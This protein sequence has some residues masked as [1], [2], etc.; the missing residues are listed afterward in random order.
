MDFKINSIC[1]KNSSKYFN[2]DNLFYPN[3][4][5]LYTQLMKNC[6]DREL[7][8]NAFTQSAPKGYKLN[9]KWSEIKVNDFKK[10]DSTVILEIYSK[11][12]I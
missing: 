7:Y 3:I 8:I 2:K 1:E 4:Y 12:E 5:F 10:L 6:W 9:H 11:S